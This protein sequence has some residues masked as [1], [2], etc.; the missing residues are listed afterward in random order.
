M[1]YYKD[2]L[3]VEPY[4]CPEKGNF[5]DEEEMLRDVNYYPDEKECINNFVYGYCGGSCE[6]ELLEESTLFLFEDI[7]KHFGFVPFKTI[8]EEK[9]NGKIV[10]IEE[11][12]IGFFHDEDRH[13]AYIHYK[14]NRELLP[15]TISSKLDNLVPIEAFYEGDNYF[16]T[17]RGNEISGFK[18]DLY[19]KVKDVI[20]N[21]DGNYPIKIEKHQVSK[22]KGILAVFTDDGSIFLISGLIGDIEFAEE[23]RSIISERIE[24]AQPF[25]DFTP[26]AKVDWDKLKTNKGAYF[27]SLCEKILNSQ[28]NLFDLQPIGK[29]NASDR[30]RDFI[31][32][33]NVLD[34][35]GRKEIKWLVQ[36]KYSDNSISPKTIPDWTNRLIEHNADGYWLMTNNDLTPSLF[37]QLN[38]ATKNE[39]ISIA[40]R[41][42]QRN[43]FDI[44]LN[45]H[46]EYF[47][48]DDFDE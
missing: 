26:Y 9:S 21:I 45:T 39:K 6:R 27:E 29:T 25:F 28:E 48:N 17:K 12:I 22:D 16:L 1:N 19:R 7:S 23:E 13:V 35:E 8:K 36:C 34:L 2:Q 31:V 18:I 5:L 44:L 10:E 15:E 24:N 30:G 14:A 40:M 3:T 38:D 32:K 33:E 20:S 4:S 11:K 43:K 42:W 41:I 37:D 46:K 47:T